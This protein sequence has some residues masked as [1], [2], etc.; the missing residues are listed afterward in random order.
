VIR[1]VLGLLDE[2]EVIGSA[3][4]KEYLKNFV[5]TTLENNKSD[6]DN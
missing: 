3:A 4:F 1:F 5:I 6:F 2:V